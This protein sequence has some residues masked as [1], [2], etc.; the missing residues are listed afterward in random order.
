MGFSGLHRNAISAY[1]QY[2]R[3]AHDAEAIGLKIHINTKSNLKPSIRFMNLGFRAVKRD[4][5]LAREAFKLAIGCLV[6]RP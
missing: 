2:C 1:D 4:S 3:R 6:S 5:F